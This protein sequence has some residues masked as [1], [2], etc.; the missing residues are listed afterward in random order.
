[1]AQLYP[2][3]LGSLFVSSY[4]SQGYGEDIRIRLLAGTMM[5]QRVYCSIAWQR[6]TSLVK[7]F[8]HE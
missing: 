1:M 7:Q 5:Q 4:D 6:M 3:A 2:Q 8:G